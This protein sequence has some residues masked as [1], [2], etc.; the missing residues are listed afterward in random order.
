[1]ARLRLCLW[2]DSCA[3]V[4]VFL[5]MVASFGDSFNVLHPMSMPSSAHTA[6]TTRQQGRQL[7]TT[8]TCSMSVAPPPGGT[9]SMAYMC[10]CAQCAR[11]LRLEEREKPEKNAAAL[12]LLGR[13]HTVKDSSC[14]WIHERMVT[15]ARGF[16]CTL[17][18]C[19][20][21]FTATLLH[22]T[23]LVNPLYCAVLYLYYTVHY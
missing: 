8:T 3:V 6:I 14:P 10:Y 17:S 15:L 9:L 13:P 11:L 22:S 1:M 21:V 20:Y 2:A 5:S 7:S 23:A 19:I 16:P 4:A 12:Y 18:I